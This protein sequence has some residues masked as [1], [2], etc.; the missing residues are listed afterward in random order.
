MLDLGEVDS[1]TLRREMIQLK[2]TFSQ[3]EPFTYGWLTRFNQQVTTKFH[4]DGARSDE[5][6]LMLG[7]EPS[8]IRSALFMGEGVS[9]LGDVA[10][11][12]SLIPEFTAGHSYI[13]VINNSKKFGVFHKA[14]I[15]NPDPSQS[16]VIN[17]LQLLLNDPQPDETPARTLEDE[18]IE[19]DTLL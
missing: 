5:S 12:V 6:I 13:V 19:R 9:A 7:Y 17:S 11:K 16:R 2:R 8:V 10:E 4:Q 3:F 14:V 18:W 15:L 1:R